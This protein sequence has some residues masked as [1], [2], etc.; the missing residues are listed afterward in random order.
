[1]S[2]V[3]PV[4]PYQQTFP[5]P[6]DTSHLGQDRTLDMVNDIMNRDAVELVT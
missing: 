6:V 5:D 3:C 4:Y 2:A 1:M